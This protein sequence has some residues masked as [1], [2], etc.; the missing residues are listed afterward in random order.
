MLVIPAGAYSQVLQICLREGADEFLDSFSV[1]RHFRYGNVLTIV[2][3]PVPDASEAVILFCCQRLALLLE[4]EGE[5]LMGI[6]LVAIQHGHCLYDGSQGVVVIAHH[7]ASWTSRDDFLTEPL[8]R[9][10]ENVTRRPPRNHGAPR[11][12]RNCSATPYSCP[13]V[14][15]SPAWNARTTEFPG[16]SSSRR[17]KHQQSSSRE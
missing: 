10:S 16:L 11:H 5:R 14:C 8:F 9:K 13:S 12:S 1:L 17:P 2:V 15:Q 3:D 4:I 6:D 7:L